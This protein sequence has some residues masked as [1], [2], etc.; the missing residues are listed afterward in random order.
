MR[1]KLNTKNEF[2]F[3]S[4]KNKIPSLILYP[5]IQNNIYLVLSVKYAYYTYCDSTMEHSYNSKAAT[6]IQNNIYLVAPVNMHAADDVLVGTR[7]FGDVTRSMNVK[8]LFT[9][10][11]LKN[12][13][14]KN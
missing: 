12:F 2:N 5:K 6:I 4:N 13:I 14:S 11:L 10:A 3:L 9:V 1:K 8:V 7:L